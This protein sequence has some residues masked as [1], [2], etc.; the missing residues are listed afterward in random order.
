MVVPVRFSRR[1][2]LPTAS[3]PGKYVR[4]K[5]SF[6][7]A[8]SGFPG[9]SCST[10]KRP[11][12]RE[13]PTTAKYAGVTVR[14]AAVAMPSAVFKERP[15]IEKSWKAKPDPAGR[16]DDAQTSMT[17]GSECIRLNNSWEKF[18]KSMPPGYLDSGNVIIIV[19]TRSGRKPRSVEVTR[20]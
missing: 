2:C 12:L 20:W 5:L 11:S 16:F 1:I 7:A 3:S 9:P 10:K 17:P 6:T 4:A 15:G 18:A 14:Y 19:S 8:M 13:V